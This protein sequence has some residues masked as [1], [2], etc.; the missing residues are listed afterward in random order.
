M[1][2]GKIKNFIIIVLALANLFLLG[3]FVAEKS[4]Q[5]ELERNA[6]SQ[7]SLLYEQAGVSLPVGLDIMETVSPGKSFSRDLNTE[8]GM[9]EAVLGKCSVTD[10]GGSIYVY[11]GE[12]G[13]AKFHGTGEF[14]MNL[15]YG[16]VQAERNKAHAAAKLLEKMG[17]EPGE[18]VLEEVDGQQTTVVLNCASGGSQVYNARVTMLFSGDTLMIV[19]GSRVFDT[20]AKSSDAPTLDAGTALV[21]FL[22]GSK[23]KGYVYSSV[24]GISAGYTLNVDMLESCALSPVWYIQTDAGSYIL[25]AENGKLESISY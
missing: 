15:D 20:A 23:E 24:T 12:K 7:L 22:R 4:R 16:V 19:Y 5:R 17:M 1:E 3:I 10:Q 13:S 14:N 2:T 18:C 8:L 11:S 25:G 9:V 21:R 6:Y